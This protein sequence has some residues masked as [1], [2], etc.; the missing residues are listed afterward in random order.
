MET[1]EEKDLRNKIEEA[2]KREGFRIVPL[3]GFFK[4]DVK[5]EGKILPGSDLVKI[6]SIYA[7]STGFRTSGA[8]KGMMLSSG[9]EKNKII[10]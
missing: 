5:K 9:Y 8:F 10:K 4:L 7:H 3:N 2:L 1:N 6:E